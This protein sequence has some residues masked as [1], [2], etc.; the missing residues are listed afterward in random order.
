MTVVSLLPPLL[1]GYLIDEVITPVLIDRG[2]LT[3]DGVP[4]PP[5]DAPQGPPP[6]ISPPAGPWVAPPHSVALLAAV[7]LGLL[8]AHFGTMILNGARTWTLGWLGQRVTLR[9]ADPDLQL[10]AGPLSLPST[11]ATAPAAS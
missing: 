2:Q 6:G 5:A 9:P 10:P 7:V 8:G 11:P 4:V 3:A 1:N